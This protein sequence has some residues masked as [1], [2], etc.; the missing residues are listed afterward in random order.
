M[1]D[2]HKAIGQDMLKEPAET[3]HDVE[4]G[5]AWAYTAHFTVGEG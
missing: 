3:L 1:P 5:G 2:F 4:V